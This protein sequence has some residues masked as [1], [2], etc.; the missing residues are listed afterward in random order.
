MSPS[1]VEI[2]CFSGILKGYLVCW[3]SCSN[4]FLLQL[5]LV[6]NPEDSS[7]GEEDF[8]SGLSPDEKECLEYLLQT[9][10][11]LDKDLLEDDDEVD[12]EQRTD[13]IG[14]TEERQFTVYGSVVTF[15]TNWPVWQGPSIPYPIGSHSLSWLTPVIQYMQ[16]Q[17]TP[18]FCSPSHQS[19]QALLAPLRFVSIL[20]FRAGNPNEGCVDAPDGCEKV[21]CWPNCE[22]RNGKHG[23]PKIN[24]GAPAEPNALVR[25]PVKPGW[26]GL[27]H[28]TDNERLTSFPP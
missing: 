17:P 1:E 6:L 21:C 11:T 13:S 20:P 19:I 4:S 15:W 16:A 3:K 23:P 9:I 7:E 10:N 8:L 2:H 14:E 26:A 28:K 12:Q 27:S 18:I 22:P 25:S 24:W 5:I